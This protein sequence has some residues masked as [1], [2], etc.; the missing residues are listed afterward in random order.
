[1]SNVTRL[2][3][4]NGEVLMD[5]RKGISTILVALALAALAP[6]EVPA[7]E[8]F[9]RLTGPQIR[10]RLVGKEITDG[11][12]W[13][14]V[15]APDGALTSY[16]MS[17]K[18]TGKWRIQKDELCIERGKDDGDCYQVWLSGKNVQLRRE[19]SD[20]PLEGLLQAPAV[21]R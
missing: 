11:V 2:F 18:T 13:A 19:G 9:Q 10:A 21:R 20:L 5:G 14:D 12:H 3:E 15:F 1:M 17:R 16:S 6:I 7:A 8:K 4:R